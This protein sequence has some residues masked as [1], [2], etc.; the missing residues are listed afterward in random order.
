MDD[1]IVGQIENLT[2]LVKVL[3]GRIDNLDGSISKLTGSTQNM[4]QSISNAEKSVGGIDKAF[5]GA[6]GSLD[7]MVGGLKKGSDDFEKHSTSLSSKVQRA[8]NDIRRRYGIFFSAHEKD[9]LGHQKNLLGQFK[10]Y[11]REQAE[12]FSNLESSRDRAL[13]AFDIF[14]KQFGFFAGIGTKLFKIFTS[15]A[16]TV[17]NVAKFL[18][19][20]PLKTLETVLDI[21]HSI[22]EEFLAISQ[23]LE[24]TQ[25]QISGTS[26]QGQGL[27]ALTSEVRGLGG[28]FLNVGSE[29]ARTFGFGLQ[30]QQAMISK[31]A[32]KVAALGSL[33][34]VYG[35]SYTENGILVERAMSALGMSVEDNM[36][37]ARRSM[38]EGIHPFQA[39]TRAIDASTAASQAFGIDQ[40]QIA[41]GMNE[42][43]KNVIEFSHISEPELAG[44]VAQA[45]QLGIE[46]KE[47]NAV[48]S[49]FTTFDQAAESAALLSQT[50]GM[51][52]DAMDIIRAEDPMEI[53]N[54]F[55]EGMQQTGRDF[56]DLNRHEKA[57]L[58]QYT[59]LSG[60]ALQTAM[61]F[62]GIG[63]SYEEL[64]KKMEENSPQAQLKDAVKEMSA[65][66]KE[67][68]NVGKKLTSPFQA[69]AEGMKDAMVKNAGFQRSMMRLSNGIQNIYTSVLNKFVNNDMLAAFD[70]IVDAFEG[71]VDDKVADGLVKVAQKFADFLAVILDF[72]STS[73]QISKSFG[74]LQDAFFENPLVVRLV[75]LGKV[76]I[77]NIVSGFIKSLP[78]LLNGFVDLLR[79]F[80]GTINGNTL[81]AENS[82]LGSWFGTYVG[83][84]WDQVSGQVPGLMRTL[85]SELTS[86]IK[87]SSALVMDLGLTIG[88]FIL[89]GIGNALISPEGMTVV[90]GSIAAVGATTYGTLAAGKYL[91]GGRGVRGDNL[92]RTPEGFLNAAE[93]ERQQAGGTPSTNKRG[94]L[95]KGLGRL[96]RGARFVGGGLALGAGINALTSAGSVVGDLASGRGVQA[97]DIGTILGT[98]V[99][100]LGGP[101]GMAAG[102]AIGGLLTEKVVG[103]FSSDEESR[104]D[105]VANRTQQQTHHNEQMTQNKNLSN[106][107]NQM[108]QR[109]IEINLSVKQLL[110]GKELTTSILST[111]LNGTPQYNITT[112]DDGTMRLFHR[113]S[114]TNIGINAE[115]G[116]TS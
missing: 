109:P 80:N 26:R 34:N 15:V 90:G 91:M 24:D 106:A 50:F 45:A 58:S 66:I 63:L 64:Q 61:S 33:G 85:I 49:K 108:N 56:K 5:A 104:Q 30:G 29:A 35:T 17:I 10:N 77:G 75:D 68:M 31:T 40:K 89:K 116:V 23:S 95:T 96:G 18:V 82:R 103:F 114:Q 14:K 99:G 110:D 48:F 11:A 53:I 1:K 25:D 20:L 81:S 21:A 27:R 12:I 94:F 36:F 42:L 46:A 28:A 62:E 72:N 88:G 83:N 107:V 84:A 112:G 78:T 65:S 57:L 76:M 98:A 2:N 73:N 115:S 3:G 4:S 93:I 86:A 51:T 67:F 9:Q 113:G 87:N 60:E 97:R 37:L 22:R 52:V 101:I 111:M 55:R 19:T 79:L 43:R 47:L 16:E 32:E 70:K 13:F 41:R 39:L 44:V 59:G 102:S 7:S 6:Q 100:A 92:P 105:S 69:M 8:T 71:L 54:Q 74:N 38:S